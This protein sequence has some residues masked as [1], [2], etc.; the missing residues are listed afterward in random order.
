[1][2]PTSCHHNVAPGAVVGD[3]QLDNVVAGTLYKHN[4]HN[5][6]VVQAQQAQSQLDNV[7]P[8]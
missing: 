8:S 6:Q 1:M 7:A 2:L 3:A 5:V 4:V